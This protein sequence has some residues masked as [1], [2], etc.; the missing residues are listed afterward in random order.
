MMVAVGEA[1]L[2]ASGTRR[3]EC[4]GAPA[5]HPIIGVSLQRCPKRATEPPCCVAS[6]EVV[7][8]YH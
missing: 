1:E 3:S 5:P 2:D 8:K 6:H 4:A 7:E